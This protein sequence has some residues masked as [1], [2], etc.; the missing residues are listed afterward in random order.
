[1]ARGTR[2]PVPV[3]AAG[4][5]LIAVAAVALMRLG[6]TLLVCATAW[7]LLRAVSL[8][9]RSAGILL[10]PLLLRPALT[11]GVGPLLP[12]MAGVMAAA[13]PLLPVAARGLVLRPI[14]RLAWL[15][16]GGTVARRT[17]TI[18]VRTLGAV[19]AVAS[20]VRPAV[21]RPPACRT[22]GPLEL[23]LWPPEAPHFLEIGLGAFALCSA[24]LS[25][26]LSVRLGG[27]RSGILRRNGGA[28][29]IGP[30]RPGRYRFHD[31]YRFHVS[32]R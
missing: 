15:G 9:L 19:A 27:R 24:G 22:F 4:A 1:M 16:S 5:A 20:R 7:T 10:R 13:L 26:C 28:A 17:R 23:G 12:S 14:L 2:I 11:L 25:D 3:A 8:G 18:L 21:M 32:Q 31:R 30:S 29:G 6:A